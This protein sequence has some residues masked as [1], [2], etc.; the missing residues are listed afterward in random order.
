MYIVVSLLYIRGHFTL[1]QG[2]VIN[3]LIAGSNTGIGKTTALDLAKRGAR[4]ILACRNK[5][6]AEAAVYDIRKVNSSANLNPSWFLS[7]F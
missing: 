7:F 5:Q 1:A 2:W 4:V 3:R 6:K